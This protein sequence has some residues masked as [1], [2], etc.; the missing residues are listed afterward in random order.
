[1]AEKTSVNGSTGRAEMKNSGQAPKVKFGAG[2][3]PSLPLRRVNL[4]K[5]LAEARIHLV[6]R[7]AAHLINSEGGFIWKPHKE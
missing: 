1:L 4:P 3:P 7:F 6:G 2:G 5:L